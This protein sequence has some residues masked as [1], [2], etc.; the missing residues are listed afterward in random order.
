LVCG[1]RI[2]GRSVDG[3]ELRIASAE[4]IHDF[5]TDFA[6]R[7]MTGISIRIQIRKTKINAIR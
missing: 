5:I 4:T 6:R 7:A 2:A 3:D 1:L